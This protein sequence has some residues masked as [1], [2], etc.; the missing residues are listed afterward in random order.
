MLEP[1]ADGFGS[2][3]RAAEKLPAETW[4]TFGG[5][6]DAGE[7]SWH[8]ALRETS[9]EIGFTA[10]S[11]SSLSTMARRIVESAGLDLANLRELSRDQ[12][13]QDWLRDGGTTEQEL[14]RRSRTPRSLPGPRDARDYRA[15]RTG[16]RYQLILRGE[17][18]PSTAWLFADAA[19]GILVFA[20][21]TWS[22]DRVR[23]LS[24]RLSMSRTSDRGGCLAVTDGLDGLRE[25][26]ITPAAGSGRT[27]TLPRDQA[28]SG[29]AGHVL[30]PGPAC[31]RLVISASLLQTPVVA[32]PTSWW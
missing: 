1:E 3:L 9:Q 21:R 4:L 10:T 14:A 7:T 26:R 22:T 17:C 28:L 11:R 13:L 18:G 23:Q 16:Y 15:Q 5:V 25:A 19:I 31:Y 30:C 2:F 20:A 12:E 32:G 27:F 8:A 29:S 24:W 6:I